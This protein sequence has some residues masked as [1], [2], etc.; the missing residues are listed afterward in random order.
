MKN[1]RHAKFAIGAAVLYF[2]LAGFSQNL[3]AQSEI[4]F[5]LAHDTVVVVSMLADGEGP[6][7]FVLDTGTDTSVVDLA[8]ARKLSLAPLGQIEMNTLTGTQTLTRSSL[9]T[10]QVGSAHVENVEVLVQD[11]AEFRKVDS[12]IQG[13][14]G[15]NFLSQ[16]NYL[17]D[18]RKRVLRIEADHEIRDSVDSESVPM[19]RRENMMMVASEV[20]SRGG[21][22][23]RLLLDSGANLVVLTRRPSQALDRAT[24]QNWLEVTSSGQEGIEIG[25]VRALTV[26][27]QKF[28]DIAVA[29][30]APQAADAERVEDGLLP[31][32]LFSALYVN[33]REGLLMFNP[34]IRKN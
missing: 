11:L 10:L 15:Q 20:Q 28:H 2:T 34:R 31:T 6:F 9:R 25:H 17:L 5:S 4:K 30:P 22:K 12:H 29:L 14:V 7:D 26:G 24:Q 3:H 32:S 27:A 33:N 19:E 13:I 1:T 8:V 16:F 21:A 23:L 18:Y